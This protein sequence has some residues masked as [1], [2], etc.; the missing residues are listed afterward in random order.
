MSHHDYVVVGAGSAGA[1]VAARLAEDPDAR[2]LLLESGPVDD[3]PSIRDAAGQL[4]I[5][6]S[7][8]DYAYRTVPQRGADGRQ[9]ELNAGRVLGGSSSINGMIYVRGDR[10][11]FDGWAYLGCT[12]WDYE[13]V[14][15]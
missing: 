8:V 5:L 6:F 9:L 7:E 3:N 13:S 2:V 10:S 14:L 15:P 12:G 1:V 4:K 11:D